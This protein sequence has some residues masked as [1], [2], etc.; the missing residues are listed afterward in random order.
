[1]DHPDQAWAGDITYI[2]LITGFGY[3]FAIIDWFSRYVIEWELF[4]TGHFHNFIIRHPIS[5]DE[6]A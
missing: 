4:R 5:G 6:A 3:L 2:P 1:M